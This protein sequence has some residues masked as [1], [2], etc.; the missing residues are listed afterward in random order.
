MMSRT[1]W[2]GALLVWSIM[3]CG[4]D[5][6]ALPRWCI[7]PPPGTE[8]EECYY[9]RNDKFLPEQPTPNKPPC[10]CLDEIKEVC[11]GVTLAKPGVKPIE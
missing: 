7:C 10:A 11:P 2:A 1:M 9:T 5:L 8:V 6:D 3:G 4:V